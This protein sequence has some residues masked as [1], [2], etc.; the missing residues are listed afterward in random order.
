MLL[1]H[2]REAATSAAHPKGEEPAQFS[3]FLGSCPCDN[4]AMMSFLYVHIAPLLQLESLKSLLCV[5]YS[6]DRTRVHL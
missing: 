1:L 5:R 4:Q 6:L 3:S 2:S